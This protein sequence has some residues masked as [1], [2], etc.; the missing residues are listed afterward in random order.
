M[1]LN[2]STARKRGPSRHPTGR[3]PFPLL[4]PIYPIT[5]IDAGFESSSMTP[6]SALSA[7]AMPPPPS[8]RRYHLFKITEVAAHIFFVT[9]SSPFTWMI[10]PE[11]PSS[12]PPVSR[13]RITTPVSS[14]T[15]SV[16]PPIR[17]LAPQFLSSDPCFLTKRRLTPTIVPRPM[18][19]TKTLVLPLPPLQFPPAALA[20]RRLLLSPTQP[21]QSSTTLKGSP[22]TSSHPVFHNVNDLAAHH[23]IPTFLP[24]TPRTVTRRTPSSMDD[25]TPTSDKD[26]FS[27]LCSEYLTML[28]TTFPEISLDAASLPLSSSDEQA[29]QATLSIL[30]PGDSSAKPSEFLTSSMESP[31]DDFLSTPGLRS[32]DFSPDFTS[33]LIADGD[34]FGAQFH[35]TP[36]FDD[37][38]L[39]EPPPSDKRAMASLFPS[40]NLDSMYT[41]S[42][43]TPALDASP[44]FAPPP[45]D[46]PPIFPTVP[47]RTSRQTP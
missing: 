8:Q 18:A 40:V 31:F 46:F 21:S 25:M 41:I 24:P 22:T 32:D 29:A 16:T 13:L 15:L 5:I 47:V 26:A 34:D 38:G 44:L 14:S 33:P 42:P 30:H 12:T 17:S 39:F 36:L 20:R 27:P 9:R 4:Q 19:P 3:L 45:P 11:M 43:A 7:F 28:D 1:P 23:G 2:A 6:I 37:A 10:N 35:H